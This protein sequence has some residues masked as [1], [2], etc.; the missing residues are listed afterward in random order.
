M[1]TLEQL[2]EAVREMRKRERATER[3]TSID[4]GFAAR[5]LAREVKAQKLVD[6]LLSQWDRERRQGRLF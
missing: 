1:S 6:D 4:E 2:A 3:A 5:S